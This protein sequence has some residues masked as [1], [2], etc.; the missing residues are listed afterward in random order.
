VEEINCIVTYFRVC[1]YDTHIRILLGRRIIV[2]A[3]TQMDKPHELVF[4]TFD[5]QGDLAVCLQVVHTVYD[6]ASGVLQL[7]CQWTLFS[8]S[9][10][11]FNSTSTDT[12][13]PFSAASFKAA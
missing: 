10:L 8:S 3:R 4:H 12:C 2:V 7:F 13:L 1:R 9:N 6:M 5:D 11:A